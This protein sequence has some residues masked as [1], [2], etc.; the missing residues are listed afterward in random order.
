MLPFS[1]EQK[2]VCSKSIVV[3]CFQPPGF[4]MFIVYSILNL[5]ICKTELKNHQIFL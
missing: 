5:I 4:N 3:F 1:G 2:Y